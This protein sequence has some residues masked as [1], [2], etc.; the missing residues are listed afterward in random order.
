MTESVFWYFDRF[1]EAKTVM[2]KG[3]Q[4]LPEPGPGQAIVAL[5][6]VG[7]NQAENRYL[8]GKHFPPK[9]FPACLSHEAVG[10]IVALGPEAKDGSAAGRWATGDRV[11]FVPMLIDMAGMG[12]LRET[13]VYDLSALAPVPEAYSDREGAAYWMGILTMAGA[14]EMA[15]I[16]PETAKGKTVA[17]T[18]AAGG[19][20]IVA[21]KLARAWGAEAFATTRRSEK[22]DRLSAFA[23][24]VAVV[25]TPDD[26]TRAL[27]AWRPGGVDAVIDPLGGGFVAAAVEALVPGG[28]FVSYEMIAGATGAY[29][30]PA[31]MAHDASLH[32]YTV[33][34]PLRHPGLLERLLDIGMRYADSATPVLAADYA[35]DDAPEAFAALARSAHVGKIT[36]S[37]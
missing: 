9:Q 16:G 3:R 33:F 7:L 4:V 10:E 1:G 23:E 25:E 26:L 34:R 12:V 20:G 30:I 35:F 22:V 15:G 5:R 31:L 32:G 8:L 37:I 27:R 17:F 14:M 11:A 28:Q 29:D 36:I 18:A 6:A 2:Q 19:M 21:L 13:G 24:R